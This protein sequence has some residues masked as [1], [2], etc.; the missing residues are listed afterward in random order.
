MFEFTEERLSELGAS[1]TTR[2]IKQQPRL[3]Q[4]TLENYLKKENEINDYLSGILD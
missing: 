1:I 4:E 3:W 2:E